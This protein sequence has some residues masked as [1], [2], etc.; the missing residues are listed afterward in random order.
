MQKEIYICI[1]FGKNYSNEMTEK[2]LKEFA[3]NLEKNQLKV[4]QERIKN[5]DKGAKVFVKTNY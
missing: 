3:K 4:F 2:Q 5:I 1:K